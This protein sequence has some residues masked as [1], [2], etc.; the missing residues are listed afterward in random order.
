M[1]FVMEIDLQILRA[2]TKFYCVVSDVA[3]WLWVR[4]LVVLD[5]EVVQQSN[6]N[7]CMLNVLQ[8]SPLLSNTTFNCYK[9]TYYIEKLL[10]IE[11][12]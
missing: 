4:E 8:S 12:I 10:M 9:L 6:S 5:R 2:V 7:V 1:W 3:L 11:S